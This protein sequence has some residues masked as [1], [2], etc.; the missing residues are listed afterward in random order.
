MPRGRP[1]KPTQL[2][3]VQGTLRSGRHA[4]RQDEVQPEGE[5]VKPLFVKGRAARIW[6]EYAGR[7]FWL[8]VADSHIFA[9]WCGLGA[10]LERGVEKVPAARI[11]QWRGLGGDLGISP[12]ARARIGATQ[13]PRRPRTQAN[14]YLDR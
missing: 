6:K 7:C 3:V 1:P 11:A 12:A 14:K 5:P 10:E 8:T 2:H 9:V 13:R 4:V